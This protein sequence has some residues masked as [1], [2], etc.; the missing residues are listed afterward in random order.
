MS[1]DLKVQVA[2]MTGKQQVKRKVTG[3]EH[4]RPNQRKLQKEM[5]RIQ[6]FKGRGEEMKAVQ[7]ELTGLMDQKLLQLKLNPNSEN[8][9]ALK[10]TGH[11]LREVNRRAI[12]WDAQ[13]YDYLKGLLDELKQADNQDNAPPSGDGVWM[14]F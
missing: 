10:R 12:L 8:L 3:K 7:A 6:V 9:Q 5:K 11:K 14:I 4:L 2:A 1:R 13:V